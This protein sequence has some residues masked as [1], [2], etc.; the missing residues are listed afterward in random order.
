MCKCV[1]VHVCLGYMIADVHLSRFLCLSLYTP[2]YLRHRIILILLK[3]MDTD[4]YQYYSTSKFPRC[5]DNNATN[6]NTYSLSGSLHLGYRKQ[7]L[8]PSV[9]NGSATIRSKFLFHRRSKIKFFQSTFC[10]HFHI[11]YT[12]YCL[13]PVG[14]IE[15]HKE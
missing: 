15:L 9:I 8:W 2:I 10:M 13:K 12:L 6:F 5:N 4:I 3:R 14:V 11:L 7:S 1:I